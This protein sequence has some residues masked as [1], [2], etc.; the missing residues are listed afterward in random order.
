LGGLLNATF[1]NAVELII[2][3][4]ALV[5]GEIRVV[6]NAMI[7]SVL[8]NSLLVLGCCFFAGGIK[9]HE[10]GYKVRSAQINIGML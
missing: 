7:G 10:Q 5:K 1:G 6:Q 2:A 4:L 3:I 8:S 9:Y